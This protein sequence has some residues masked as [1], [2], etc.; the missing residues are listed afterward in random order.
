VY[1]DPE[2]EGTD[3]ARDAVPA[4]D[5]HAAVML[6]RTVKRARTALVEAVAARLGSGLRAVH[7]QVFDHLDPE[8]TRLTVLAERAGMTHQ[9]MGELVTDL[10]GRGYLERVPDPADGRARLIRPTPAGKDELRRAAT[11]LDAIHSEWLRE[12]G[13]VP[14]S[15]VV[16][17][18]S[19]LIRVCEAGE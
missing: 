14:A 11:V 3:G 19:A 4:G 5:G 17:G 15:Q 16:G 6:A 10:A 7:T 18:L 8:G 13:P 9:A 12:L 2:S 1:D